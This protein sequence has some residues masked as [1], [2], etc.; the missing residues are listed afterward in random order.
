MWND[1]LVL[2]IP[3]SGPTD[4]SKCLDSDGS[5]TFRGKWHYN[6]VRG[7]YEGNPVK[8]V[9]VSDTVASIRHKIN[10]V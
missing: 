3:N 9:D 8:S 1:V 2:L 6:E 4:E 10:A 7:Q 5:G